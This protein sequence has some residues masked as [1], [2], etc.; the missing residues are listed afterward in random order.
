MTSTL[1]T[2]IVPF[3]LSDSEKRAPMMDKLVQSIPDRSDIE[4]IM[5]DD[6]SETQY[7]P[8]ERT[9]PVVLLKQQGSDRYAGRARSAGLKAA[10]GEWICFAD[11]DDYFTSD[12]PKIIDTLPTTKE[13]Q[14]LFFCESR[15]ENGDE[16]GRNLYPNHSAYLF[17]LT[18]DHRF[19]TNHY[20][21]W[22]RIIRKSHIQQNQL[23]FC[24][25][26]YAN[27]VRFST[28]LALTQPTTKVAPYVGYCVLEADNSL[29]TNFSSAAFKNRF[30]AHIEANKR[31]KKGGMP[32]TQQTY[33]YRMRQWY[34]NQKFLTITTFIYLFLTG[35][36]VWRSRWPNIETIPQVWPMLSPKM[37]DALIHITPEIAQIMSQGEQP[38]TIICKA[39]KI[40]K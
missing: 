19:L 32:E 27:D 7:T 24:S 8:P 26:R 21:P 12:F 15:K 35:Q 14:V 1:L 13:Q 28:T 16:A 20:V 29:M 40:S 25:R 4:V 3:H 37:K 10:K 31:L 17:A 6:Q 22:G 34:P 36:I 18:K 11:S 33:K 39:E 9:H 23:D 5:V 38:E 2:I 30:G